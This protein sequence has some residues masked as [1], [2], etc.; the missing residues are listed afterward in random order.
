MAA[1][2]VERGRR[3]KAPSC[4]R[5][6]PRRAG[7]AG[8]GPV[9]CAHL[10][11]DVSVR[12]ALA[13]F[14][15]QF[16]RPPSKSLTPAD[17]VRVCFGGEA[18]VYVEECFCR[19]PSQDRLYDIRNAINHGEVDAEN[20]KELIRIEARLIKLLRMVW[21]MFGGL[22]PMPKPVDRDTATST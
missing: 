4:P 12:M 11:T 16:P 18:E 1:Q 13:V 15:R 7:E 10:P 21:G 8:G 3:E 17:S 19:S 9:W 20:P 5:G 2:W 14:L 6:G 22:I